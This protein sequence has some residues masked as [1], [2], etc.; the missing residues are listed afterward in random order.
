MFLV[1]L[2][3]PV[4]LLFR[5]YL[6][7]RTW[8]LTQNFSGRN[9][10]HVRDLQIFPKLASVS[11]GYFVASTVRGDSIHKIK[12]LPRFYT[13]IFVLPFVYLSSSSHLIWIWNLLTLVWWYWRR[14]YSDVPFSALGGVQFIPEASSNWLIVLFPQ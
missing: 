4:F 10:F 13:V 11:S 1:C 3:F 12:V 8:L 14:L 5:H 2:L 9:S 7:C 6:T